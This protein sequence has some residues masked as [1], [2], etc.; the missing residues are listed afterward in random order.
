MQSHNCIKDVKLWNATPYIIDLANNSNFRCITYNMKNAHACKSDMQ[1]YEEF[2]HSTIERWK[3]C[4]KGGTLVILANSSIGGAGRS[5]LVPSFALSVVTLH[6]IRSIGITAGFYRLLR[7]VGAHSTWSLHNCQ[8]L[9]SNLTWTDGGAIFRER[10]SG[11]Y[12]EISS[13]L[14]IAIWDKIA[15]IAISKVV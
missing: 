15:Q 2:L 12:F 3:L 5:N 13:L 6:P 4:R 14:G 7:L 1:Q 11:Y 9:L 10:F 8:P